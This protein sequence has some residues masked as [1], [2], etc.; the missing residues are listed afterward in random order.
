MIKRNS[1][2]NMLL[3]ILS[4]IKCNAVSKIIIVQ[5]FF[6]S[7]KKARN[8]G[9]FLGPNSDLSIEFAQKTI[10]R[11]FSSDVLLFVKFKSV[12]MK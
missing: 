4:M 1:Y 6:C 5:N 3:Y 11:L 2:D 7:L 8:K 10:W 12:L 9:P